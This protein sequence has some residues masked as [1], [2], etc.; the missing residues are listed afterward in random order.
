MSV[1]DRGPLLCDAA[2]KATLEARNG[3][4]QIDYIAQIVKAGA[5]KRRRFWGHR[6]SPTERRR[7][8]LRGCT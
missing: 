1:G 6:L 7:S 4:E 5:T 2:M 8:V 3:A